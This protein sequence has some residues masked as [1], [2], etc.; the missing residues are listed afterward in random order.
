MPD[1]HL[2]GSAGQLGPVPPLSGVLNS[3]FDVIYE[4]K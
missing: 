3:G 4:I 2:Y 1:K